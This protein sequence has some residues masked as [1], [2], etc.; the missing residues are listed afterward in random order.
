MKKPLHVIYIPGIADNIYRVQ[1]ALVKTWHFSGARG[2]CHEMPWFGPESY[3]A[4]FQRLLGE[5]D[6]HVAEGHDVALVGTSAGASAV[7]NAFVARPDK[8]KGVVLLCAKINY[9]ETVSQKT[10][11]RNPAFKESLEQLQANLLKL[12]ARQKERILSCY[13][14]A[15][16]T[17]PYEATA[18]PGVQERRLPQ[19]RHARAILYGITFG[20]PGFIRFLK[21][22]K[23]ETSKT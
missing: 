9:P 2:H 22:S 13:S 6:K 8:I 19:L 17:V 5:I 16:G 21:S 10:Y 11:A 20:A 1:S 4:K 23:P 18:I 3:E 7:L 14:P 15:D 12:T